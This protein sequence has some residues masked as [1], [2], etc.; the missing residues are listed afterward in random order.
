MDKIDGVLLKPLKIIKNDMGDVYHFLKNNEKSYKKFG[1]VYLSTIK[2]NVIKSWRKH[3]KMTLNIVVPVGKIKFVLFDDRR[4]S[5]TKNNFFSVILSTDN[6][7]RLTIPPKIWFSF[8]GINYK[9]IL[10][11]FADIKHDPDEVE[12]SKN[13]FINF[14]W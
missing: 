3:K 9:N 11:N 6:Y 13:D 8:K 7:S 12:I 4:T 14:K 10:I 2:Y 5:K 1:E